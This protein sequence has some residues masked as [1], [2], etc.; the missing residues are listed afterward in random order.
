M[1]KRL[2]SILL[3]SSIVLTGCVSKAEFD[4]LE[5]RVSVLESRSGLSSQNQSVK[6][7]ETQSV[8]MTLT[9]Y[10]KNWDEVSTIIEDVLGRN[11]YTIT[12]IFYSDINSFS[13]NDETFKT[14]GNGTLSVTADSIYF[15]V[16]VTDFVAQRVSYSNGTSWVNIDTPSH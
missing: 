12:S 9:T 2:V 15:Q 10:V 3:L 11:N 6:Q 5:E 14:F 8:D 4:A 13:S 7:S 1:K 16:Y